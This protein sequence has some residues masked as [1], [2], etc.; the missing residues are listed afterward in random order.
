MNFHRTYPFSKTEDITMSDR[1]TSRA[2]MAL[3]LAFFAG[4]LSSSLPT[5]LY[6]VYISLYGFSA[7]QIMTV[8]GVY[9]VG[10][11]FALAFTA[12]IHLRSDQYTRP[13]YAGLGCVL[14]SSLLMMFADKFIILILG[15]FVTGLGSGIL[16]AYINR[17]LI[18]IFDTEVSNTAALTASASLILGQA[19]GPLITGEIVH[20]SFYT[21]KAP[22]IILFIL[23]LMSSFGIWRSR[24]VINRHSTS[25]TI[26]REKVCT[27]SYKALSFRDVIVCCM[28]IFLSWA[29]ASTFMSQGPTLARTYFNVASVQ[30]VSYSLSAFLLIAGITQIVMRKKHHY[31]SLK[32]G[33]VTQ[34]AAVF[35]ALYSVHLTDPYLLFISVMLEGFA[36]GAIL[37]GAA[38][39]VNMV[40]RQSQRH[41]LINLLYIVGYAGNWLPFSLSVMMDRFPQETALNG[42]LSLCSVLS[43]CIAL[44]AYFAGRSKTK[45]RVGSYNTK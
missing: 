19:I 27:Q 8:F 23:V 13:L 5:P 12:S 1:H 35:L 32:M 34:L 24:Q 21:L 26:E 11:L 28:A 36:Y 22:Y 37:V 2:G 25:V 44:S 38:T 43:A 14:L 15:R 10:V 16:M 29:M 41:H 17:S 6:P 45:L 42:Y 18:K 33:I 30:L 4:M 39:I 31:S 7:S 40:A 20:Y 3:A 9:A